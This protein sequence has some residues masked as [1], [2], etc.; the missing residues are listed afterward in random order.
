VSHRALD[1]KRSSDVQPV[2]HHRSEEK[3]TPG[4]IVPVDIEIL[5]SGTRLDAG[6]TLRLVVQGT[7]VYRHPRPLTHPVHADTVNVGVH[8]LHTGGTHDA[9]LAIPRLRTVS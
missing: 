3:V 2:L 6:E 1:A 9:T 5:P 4:T 7:D 8:R